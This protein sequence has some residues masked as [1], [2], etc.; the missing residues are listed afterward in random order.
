MSDVFG[1]RFPVMV[2][3]NVRSIT[4]WRATNVNLNDFAALCE[5]PSKCEK[6]NAPAFFA[7]ILRGQTAEEKFRV[8]VR[9]RFGRGPRV[10]E[11]FRRGPHAGSESCRYCVGDSVVVFP[12]PAISC[13]SALYS[14]HDRGRK[15]G[16]R[17]DVFQCIGARGPVGWVVC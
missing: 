3:G 10:A 2:A 11:R 17:Q 1:A 16:D 6:N 4:G 12:V 14:Q 7:G 13:C 9:Y 5:A 8:Q 15:R